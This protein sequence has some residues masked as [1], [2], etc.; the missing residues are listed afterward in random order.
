M[1]ITQLIQAMLLLFTL[2]V[3]FTSPAYA[4]SEP[5]D[6]EHKIEQL[7]KALESKRIEHH[8][9]GMAIAV[10]KDDKV[11][12]SQGFGVMDLE[13][14]KPVTTDTLFAIGSSSK[15]FTA[16]MVGMLVD[17]N[18][19][20]WDDKISEQLPSYQF[21]VDDKILPI[22]YR[23]MLSHR[24]GYTRNDLLWFNGKASK[25]LILETAVK[26]EP[27]DKFREK[28]YYNNVMY[29][30]AGE[31][32]AKLTGQS[33]DQSLD[34]ML[35]QPLKMEDTTSIHELAMKSEHLSLGYLWNE[36]TKKHDLIPA[37][38]LNTI[39]PAGGIYSN[40]ND[41]AQWVRFQL[42][43]GKVSANEK[44]KELISSM[45]LAETHQTQIPIGNG[46][47]Y[48]LGW[49]LHEWQNQPVVEH[50]GNIDGFAAQVGLLPESKLGFVLLTNLSVTPLQ[51]ESLS[52]VWSHLAG[53]QQKTQV[54]ASDGAV[55]Y[56]E[57][58][59]KYLAN[60]GPFKETFFTFLLKDNGTP[61]LDVPGQTV[62]EL[63]DPDET[64]KWFF[65]QTNTIS[66]SFE[67][68]STG[69]VSVMRMQQNG[70]NFEIP[71]DGFEI[72]AEVEPG[73]FN[74]YLGMYDSKLLNGKVQ[75]KVQNHRLTVDIPN[76]MAY[77][78]QLPD[79]DGFRVFRIKDDTSVKFVKD[80]TGAVTALELY[81]NK[82]EL[83]ES[84]A[85]IQVAQT[86][87]LP[88]IE[89][90][91]ALRQ[92]VKQKKALSKNS[93]FK[94]T[95]EVNLK[96]SGITGELLTQFDGEDNYKHV[97]DLGVFGII[98]AV[99]NSNQGM[100]DSMGTL[101]ELHGKY[102]KQAQRDHPANQLDW[103]RYYDSIKIIGLA[104]VDDHQT[105]EIILK[106]QDLPNATVYI[107]RLT[108]DVVKLNTKM[109]LP[110][111]GAIEM[112]IF[113]EDF[114]EI[115]GL[116]L[117]FKSVVK[118]PLMGD[119]EMQYHAYKANQKFADNEFDANIIRE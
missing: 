48:G 90:I 79:A 30:A 40:V 21:S 6:I 83:V 9:P 24:T 118:N 80:E 112:N 37:R 69:Q 119:M 47:N 63:L 29:L 51:Q 105:Y 49:M 56:D 7:T 5:S 8:I 110:S 92:V 93:G 35:L 33:W 67:R 46:M 106:K 109:M 66:I 114:R 11:I 25:D 111:V 20:S 39:A 12:M 104:E 87:K 68:D 36:E 70:L 27:E 78:L 38:N 76:Q 34:H 117:P 71:K 95:G 58:M 102:L 22:T 94:L 41:M 86:E 100:S 73:T 32:V 52:L 43:Q 28:F 77:E 2:F 101:T 103:N 59:G 62:Y 19:M 84:A 96:G 50:G 99:I 75:A 23:D 17:E 98:S 16:T 61:A 60:F 3:V 14:N 31:G 85:K 13:N 44:A 54:T 65:K 4:L 107:D 91:N 64:G 15:A 81:K 10:V 42:N 74:E 18:K 1:K 116:R 115:H 55:D 113:Y 72:P 57:F 108:G 89:E 45:V 53:Q 82:K 88:S 97:M 26:A